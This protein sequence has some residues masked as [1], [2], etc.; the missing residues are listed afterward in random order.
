MGLP[1]ITSQ[2]KAAVWTAIAPRGSSNPIHC[3]DI[4]VV[5]RTNKKIIKN[6]IQALREDGKAIASDRGGYYVAERASDMDYVVDTSRG[7]LESAARAYQSVA[8][9]RE[10]LLE[11]ESAHGSQATSS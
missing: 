2:R 6:V 3:D 5:T 8:H 1:K 11:K 10:K 7:K 4:A 9:I